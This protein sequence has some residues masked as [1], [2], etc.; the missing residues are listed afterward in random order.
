MTSFAWYES[1]PTVMSSGGITTYLNGAETPKDAA[2][3]AWVEKACHDD[4]LVT[5]PT[6]AALAV[7]TK[8]ATTKQLSDAKVDI[9]IKDEADAARVLTVAEWEKAKAVA[10]TVAEAKPAE[11]PLEEKEG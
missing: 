11:E 4:T 7:I 3:Q 8:G 2:S 6:R 9:S 10:V 5:I 1:T